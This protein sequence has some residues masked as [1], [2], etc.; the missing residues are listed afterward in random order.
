MDELFMALGVT[1]SLVVALAWAIWWT[2]ASVRRDRRRQRVAAAY[3]RRYQGEPGLLGDTRPA[4]RFRG[5]GDA[6]TV[7]ELLDEAGERGDGLRLNWPEHDL[8]RAG[9]VRPYVQDEFPTAILPRVDHNRDTDD[10]Q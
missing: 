1:I 8:D 2:V 10:V 7:A 6:V 3:A 9:R 4:H 5:Q